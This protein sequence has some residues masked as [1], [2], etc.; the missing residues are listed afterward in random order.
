MPDD[1]DAP[2][3]LRRSEP[4]AVADLAKLAIFAAGWAGVDLPE[5]TATKIVAGVI[6]LVLFVQTTWFARSRVTPVAKADAAV[7]EAV[8]VEKAASAPWVAAE[9]D[10]PSPG[11]EL[12]LKTVKDLA[13]VE[14]V[15]PPAP[16]PGAIPYSPTRLPPP[17]GLD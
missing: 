15:A 2:E 14:P 11:L 16:P 4:V 17:A 13:Q 8:A 1:I 6:A 9:R 5:D 7:A 12:L 10:A 3:P